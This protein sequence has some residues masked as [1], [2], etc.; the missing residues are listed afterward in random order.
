MNEKIS[1]ALDGLK[2]MVDKVEIKEKVSQV[3]DN[4]KESVSEID[5]KE[6]FGE[7]AAKY[8][9]GGIKKAASEV[10]DTLKEAAGKA[11]EAAKSALRDFPGAAVDKGNDGKTDP[12]LVKER[13]SALNNNPR[14]TD[15]DMP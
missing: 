4:V 1:S 6:K 3:V 14:N 9:E 7:V 12:C 2:G 8:K 10:G 15:Y 5:I 11:A 13:T